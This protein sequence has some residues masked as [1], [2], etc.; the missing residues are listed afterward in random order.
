M[1]DDEGTSK[2]I[3]VFQSVIRV[4]IGGCSHPDDCL[5]TYIFTTTSLATATPR[6][7]S[8]IFFLIWNWKTNQ[9]TSWCKSHL[10][11]EI[12]LAGR[13]CIV[14]MTKSWRNRWK[15]ARWVVLEGKICSPANQSFRIYAKPNETTE[16]GDEA[17]KDTVCFISTVAAA[18]TGARSLTCTHARTHTHTHIHTHT[19][20][21]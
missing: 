11:R 14:E 20:W 5:P 2:Y 13:L 17:W 8:V 15:C 10:T 4:C 6:R 19:L 3:N 18:R 12:F 21:S 1:C 7:W 16:G 9:W